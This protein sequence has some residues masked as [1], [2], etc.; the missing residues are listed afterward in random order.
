MSMTK[1]SI[2]H[3]RKFERQESVSQEKMNCWSG[4]TLCMKIHIKWDTWDTYLTTH[5]ITYGD[6]YYARPLSNLSLVWCSLSLWKLLKLWLICLTCPKTVRHSC[7]Q[8]IYVSTYRLHSN[9]WNEGPKLTQE[10][11]L[12]QANVWHIHT[13]LYKM[14]VVH[15][16]EN[17]NLYF[18][19]PFLDA[20]KQIVQEC[21]LS[22][23]L[24]SVFFSF[25]FI[26]EGFVS[27]KKAL[28]FLFFPFANETEVESPQNKSVLRTPQRKSNETSVK[29]NKTYHII[30]YYIICK[31]QVPEATNKS[32]PVCCGIVISGKKQYRIL[33]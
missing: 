8:L 3:R 25:H 12:I 13:C 6:Y 9:L 20:R 7:W 16:G 4:L 31:T 23:S 15:W 19:S 2:V 28:V 24:R 32:D 27:S 30:S 14:F 33:G 26:W 18:S 17:P 22:S 11:E 29:V 1:C 10:T 5:W 21:G